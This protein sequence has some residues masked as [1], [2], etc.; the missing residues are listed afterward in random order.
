ML[1]VKLFLLLVTFHRHKIAS[2]LFF[3]E[4]CQGD[5]TSAKHEDS[6][7]M[8]A[9]LFLLSGILIV[10]ATEVGREQQRSR[11]A[12][13]HRQANHVSFGCPT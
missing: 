11:A 10:G 3:H 9:L 8:S 7:E 2:E 5:G 4:T 13:H 12:I 1:E 6:D